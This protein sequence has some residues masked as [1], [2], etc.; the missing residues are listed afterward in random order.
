MPKVT[1][2]DATPNE[3]ALR[4]TIDREA[5][6]STPA[7][8]KKENAADHPIAE[9]VFKVDGATSVFMVNDFVTVTKDPAESWAALQEPVQKAIE[10]V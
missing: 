6:V 9:A 7:T 8:Y 2:I 1:S 3:N 4:F 5:A 10:S